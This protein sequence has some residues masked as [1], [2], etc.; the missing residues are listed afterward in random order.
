MSNAPEPDRQEISPEGVPATP[1]LP[2]DYAA[3]IRASLRPWGL[4]LT[5]DDS[6]FFGT[7]EGREYLGERC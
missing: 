6:G 1:R 3:R 4:Y 7:P 2:P 5:T